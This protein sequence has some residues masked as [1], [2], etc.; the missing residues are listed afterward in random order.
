MFADLLRRLTATDPGHL[1]APDARLALAALMVR[2][3][4][5]DGDYAAAEVSRIDRILM[6][7][8]GLDADAAGA[9]RTEAEALEAEAP[10]TVRFTKAI[11]DAVSLEDRT[12]VIEALWSVVLADGT[13][14]ADEDSLLRLLANLLGIND[15]D[16]NLARLRVEQSL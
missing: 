14:D 4:R 16:S 5:S 11:K 1:P 8:H 9:L 2:V 6:R 7:R 13:R 12:A 15:R 10:D 3:A